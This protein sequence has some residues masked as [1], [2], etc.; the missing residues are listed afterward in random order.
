MLVLITGLPGN[1]KTLYALNWVKA[2]AEKEGRTVYYSG[3]ADLKLPWIEFDFK[4]WPG[5][6]SGS[7]LVVD[8]AQRELRPRM[9]GSAVPDYVAALETHRHKGVDIVLITQHPMLID[10]NARRL[11][12]LHF[13]VVRKFG[14][15]A[16][17]IHEWQSVK[18]S[19]DKSRDDST[20]HDFIYPKASYGWYKSAELHTHKARIP[21]RVWLL[22]LLPLLLLACAY[23]VW[24]WV[25]KQIEGPK[26]SAPTALPVAGP[27]A[28]AS[29]P[30]AP[31]AG[32][33]S[34]VDYLRQHSP[35][36]AGLAYTAPAFD[37]VT[38]PVVAPYPAACVVMG[39][40]CRC[41]TQQATR[42]EM[43][44]Y[45]CRSI[46]ERGFFVA[47]QQ[48]MPAPAPAMVAASGPAVVPG[49]PSALAAQLHSSQAG[50]GG[51]LPPAPWVSIGQPRR[52][53]EAG[54]GDIQDGPPPP[55]QAGGRAGGARSAP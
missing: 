54:T 41:Y 26:G 42:L 22:G 13:H 23:G 55:A 50:A 32:A 5:L 25:S 51:V 8:E 34:T 44:D 37:A 52:F 28:A 15:Q 45:L 40:S 18:E 48:P 4:K 36:V 1:G 3:I 12:G 31:G 7:I 10:S 27:M 53:V 19:C 6:P 35:R 24:Q 49:Q 2:K 9:H 11:V 21:M 14:T 39:A 38:A 16:A 43:A 20:R 47:W 17:T 33:V 46:V 30:A 29:V